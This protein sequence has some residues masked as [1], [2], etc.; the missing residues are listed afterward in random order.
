[1]SWGGARCRA[2]VN[3]VQT[4]T[5]QRALGFI[6][7]STHNKDFQKVQITNQKKL[8]ENINRALGY[9]CMALATETA[10]DRHRFPKP[11]LLLLRS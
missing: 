4:A 7:V 1:M 10:I 2:R 3:A 8:A 11:E 5:H 9:P 6:L